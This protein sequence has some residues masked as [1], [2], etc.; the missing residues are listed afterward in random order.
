MKQASI[1]CGFNV[2][3]DRRL[4]EGPDRNV[5]GVRDADMAMGQTL[6]FIV[7]NGVNKGFA[8]RRFFDA[9]LMGGEVVVRSN[10]LNE[11]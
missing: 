10:L 11:S 6:F 5:I 1:L 7:K 3:T 9:K 2:N 8:L 4:R